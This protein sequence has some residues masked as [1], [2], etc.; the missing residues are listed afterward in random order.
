MNQIIVGDFCD[1][2]AV[3]HGSVAI[4]QPAGQSNTVLAGGEVIYQCDSGYDLFV[5]DKTLSCI[6]VSSAHAYLQGIVPV[7]SSKSNES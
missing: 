2:P 6:A 3:T 5:G 4:S 1:V 7:C